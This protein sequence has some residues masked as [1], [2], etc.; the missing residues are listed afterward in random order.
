MQEVED[1]MQYGD[2]ASDKAQ[3]VEN[4]LT[5]SIVLTVG[6]RFYPCFNF[7]P[8]IFHSDRYTFSNNGITRAKVHSFYTEPEQCG[9]AGYLCQISFRMRLEEYLILFPCPQD[10]QAEFSQ[11]CEWCKRANASCWG[12]KDFSSATGRPKHGS[13]CWRCLE[14]NQLCSH[15]WTV[16]PQGK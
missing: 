6:R 2:W 3:Y 7:T 14:S 5:M 12:L 8:K 15:R 4:L 11:P 13:S 16:E 1:K 9:K 10:F